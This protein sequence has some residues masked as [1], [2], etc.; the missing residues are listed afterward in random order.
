MSRATLHINAASA[1]SKVL[2]PLFNAF[3]AAFPEITLDLVNFG[4]I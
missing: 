2:V 3:G 1:L 4:R